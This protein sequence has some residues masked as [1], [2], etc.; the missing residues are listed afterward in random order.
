MHNIKSAFNNED[1]MTGY[2]YL[3]SYNDENPELYYNQNGISCA[4]TT[5]GNTAYKLIQSNDSEDIR[6]WNYTSSVNNYYYMVTRDTN[7]LVL[8][9]ATL[10][11]FNNISQPVTITG[12]YDDRAYNPSNGGTIT[13]A[14]ISRMVAKNDVVIE[15]M[16]IKTYEDKLDASSTY[17]SLY[18]NYY[19]VKVGRNVVAADD[20]KYTLTA[21]IGGSNS[22]SITKKV[23]KVIVESGRY[24]NLNTYNRNST[25]TDGHMVMQYGSDYDRVSGNNQKLVIDYRVAASYVSGDTQLS[26][27]I[28]PASEII[29]KSG[30]YGNY[31]FEN[32]GG[33]TD[34]WATYQEYGVSA[35]TRNNGT[36]ALNTLKVEG[37]RIFSVYASTSKR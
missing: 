3:T 6:L 14:R 31:I 28:V 18:A 17:Q 26:N 9:S 36:M 29:I 33:Y 1:S 8:S 2:Y 16:K 20:R 30:T 37:G 10:A 21:V 24:Y 34:R 11:T 22:D 23:G 32:F 5:C 12:A 13:I 25:I 27:T 19:N 15:N 7:I 35:G 4:V